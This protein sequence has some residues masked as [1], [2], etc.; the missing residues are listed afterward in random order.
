[1]H[2]FAPTKPHVQLLCNI[3]STLYKE[4]GARISVRWGAKKTD[5]CVVVKVR[6]K[7]PEAAALAKTLVQ[8]AVDAVDASHVNLGLE[9][10]KNNRDGDDVI[11]A[12]D[13]ASMQSTLVAVGIESF[14]ALEQFDALRVPQLRAELKR[15]G[16]PSSGAKKTLVA[17]LAAH[18]S[19]GDGAD[20]GDEPDN[21]STSKNDSVHDGDTTSIRGGDDTITAPNESGI[22][23]A[24][25]TAPEQLNALDINQ[26]RGGLECYGLPTSGYKRSLIARLGRHANDGEGGVDAGLSLLSFHIPQHASGSLFGEE[27][28][29]IRSI[30]AGK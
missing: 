5:E 11:A 16:L 4:S 1:V 18:A 24:L 19:S 7:T 21:G 30:Q 12:P 20:Y 26:L 27:R 10:N 13:A 25:L 22:L 2:F 17:R 15:Y 6:A 23:S 14:G 9:D 29:V 28:S 3:F 8:N